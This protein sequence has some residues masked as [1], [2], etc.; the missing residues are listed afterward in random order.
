MRRFKSPV[1]DLLDQ[2]VS[3]VGEE[4]TTVEEFAEKLRSRIPKAT[5]SA[6]F[7]RMWTAWWRGIWS[8]RV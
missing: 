8:G 2:I 3:L 6:R 7:L 4:E 5:E 1:M